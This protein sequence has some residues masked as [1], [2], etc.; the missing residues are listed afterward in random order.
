MCNE[1]RN[2]KNALWSRDQVVVVSVVFL[3]L[4]EYINILFELRKLG[5]EY[6]GWV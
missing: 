6:T 4:T 1:R 2:F 5:Q 3:E